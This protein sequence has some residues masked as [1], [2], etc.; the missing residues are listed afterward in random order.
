LI[1]IYLI[2]L[3]F[4]LA[5][6]ERRFANI[7]ST[8]RARGNVRPILVVPDTLAAVLCR[9]NLASPADELLWTVP[10]DRWFRALS[11]VHLPPPGDSVLEFT[12]ARAMAKAYQPVWERISQDPSAVIHIGLKC[13][14]LNPPD[15]PIVYECVDSTLTQLGARH[16]IKA[17]ARPSI[18]H[19]Q[20]ERIRKSLERTMAS[21][22]PRWTTVTSPCY[23]AGYPDISGAMADR[24]PML[25]A[26]VGGLRPGRILFCSWRQLRVCARVGW[27]VAR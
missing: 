21:R 24:D 18:I 27:R 9:A 13:S 14:S 23:F 16:F 8:L 15:A 11:H 4:G 1:T 17:A 25:V 20:T 3:S 5:G 7:W 10:E 22:H 6:I 2:N 19:C 12:R 26:F